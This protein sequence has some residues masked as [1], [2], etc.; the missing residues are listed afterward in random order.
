[1]RLKN[2]FLLSRIP[3]LSVLIAPY[4]LGALLAS[5]LLGRFNWPVF[6]LGLWG[7][8]LMQLI[9]HYSGEI[10]D[11]AE[12][13]L[14]VTLEKNFFTGGSGVLVENLIS[15]KKVRNLILAIL[16]FAMAVGLILQFYFK[17]GKWT[18]AL[19]FSGILCAY[20]YS[21]PPL[22]LVSRGIGEIIIAYSF[23]WLAVNSG[24]YLQ[25]SRL[26][27]LA[28]WVCLPIACSVVN[29]I[30]INEYPDYPADKQKL[31]RNILV[32]IGKEK[33]AV[34]YAGLVAG[35][36]GAFFLALVKG[37]PVPAAIFYLPVLIISVSLAY[38]MLQGAYAD[39]KSLEKICGLTI[40]VNLGTSL[41][42]I[43][44][45]LFG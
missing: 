2:W 33:G 45:L 44:G 40:L 7:A 36:V 8:L 31:K 18:L 11:V 29:I 41:S 26:D 22:R 30:L 23:G 25:A 17:T 12:D 10:Y 37:L 14:S 38:Q 9:A 24:F 19:G 6:W 35:G 3:F 20:F 28:T 16:L 34:L 27:I 13:R 32:R 4:V 1:M 43:L 42:C 21:K 39:R 5:R 15:P